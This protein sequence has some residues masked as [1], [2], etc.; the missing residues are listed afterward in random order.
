LLLVQAYEDQKAMDFLDSLEGQVEVELE[1]RTVYNALRGFV[2]GGVPDLAF[3]WLALAVD[4]SPERRFYYQ[5]EFALYQDMGRLE[6]ARQ[7]MS[8]WQAVSGEI[9]SEMQRGIDVM[10]QGALQREQQRIEEAV[11]GGQSHED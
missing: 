8:A 6:E 2:R 5:L 1:E 4:D 11:E 9:D 3:T 7:V 10:E